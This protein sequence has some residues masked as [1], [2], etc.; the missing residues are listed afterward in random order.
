V[1]SRHPRADKNHR[2]KDQQLDQHAP[3]P[4]PQ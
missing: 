3:T 2:R 4:R 1:N